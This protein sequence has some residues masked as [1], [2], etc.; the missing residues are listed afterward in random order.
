[1]ATN[2]P[3]CDSHAWEHLPF[4]YPSRMASCPAQRFKPLHWGFAFIK[5]GMY[6]PFEF[7]YR[8][9]TAAVAGRSE[10]PH[11]INVFAKEVPAFGM[12]NQETL[13]GR[14]SRNLQFPCIGT[15]LISMEYPWSPFSRAT[16]EK[17]QPATPSHRSKRLNRPREK[18]SK[19]IWKTRSPC[20]SA[21]ASSSEFQLLILSS[22]SISAHATVR[23]AFNFCTS[24]RLL[25]TK[26]AHG[27]TACR[28]SS[29]DLCLYLISLKPIN[30]YCSGLPPTAARK[31]DWKAH[32]SL[33]SEMAW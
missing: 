25:M 13:N 24:L 9:S 27:K 30:P 3:L 32:K 33:C 22:E 23:D 26:R 29:C 4:A 7:S 11:V 21:Q 19:W 6:S 15:L 18:S 1:M 14:N 8:L 20:A 10:Q 17:V 12:C 28:R 2:C 31:I 5:P 16:C